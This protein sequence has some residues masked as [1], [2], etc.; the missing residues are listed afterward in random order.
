MGLSQ[1][2][3]PYIEAGDYSGGLREV[4]ERESDADRLLFSLERGLLLH[5]SGDFTSSNEA[6]QVAED[7]IDE[8]YT[9]S[10]SQEALSLLTTDRVRPYQCPE[11]ERVMVNVYRAL[12]Y[13]GLEL[14]DEALVEA[15]KAS[16]ALARYTADYEEPSYA[17]DAFVQYLTGLLYEWG[18][19]WNDAVVSFRRAEAAYAAAASSGGPPIPTSL[20]DSH[21]AAASRMG[22]VDEA[23]EIRDRYPKAHVTPR[24]EAEG[25]VIVLVEAGFSPALVQRRV[26]IPI[27]KSDSG[28]RDHVWTVAHHAYGRMETHHHHERELA[29]WLSISYPELVDSPP[30]IRSIRVDIG[31][32][33][34]A[35]E[36]AGDVARN[37]RLNFDDR[38]ESIVVRTI[39]RA[40]L[41]YLAKEAADDVGKGLGFVV[42]VLGSLTEQADTRSWGN[43]PHDIFLIRER[44]PAGRHEVVLSALDAYGGV[45]GVTSPFTVD[46]RP[47]EPTWVSYRF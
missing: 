15:R 4:S 28:H 18:G 19:E 6:F 44:L 25:E 32:E 12:N 30:E 39:A 13:I 2:V 14:P 16:A 11:Y 45:V 9:K 23:A 26:D 41:K 47:G 37:A 7:L 33:V 35:L 17:D 36:R 24:A 46:I 38:R 34:R 3:R 21:L 5:Y 29:Y 8:R 43:L 20:V 40:L 42:D 22:L 1:R 10:L 31:G 27:L